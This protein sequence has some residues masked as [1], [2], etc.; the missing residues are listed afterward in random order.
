LIFNCFQE[1]YFEELLEDFFDTP[2]FFKT[3]DILRFLNDQKQKSTV[4]G[5]FLTCL[6]ELIPPA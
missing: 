6:F 5:K 1:S 4:L 3:K 2:N